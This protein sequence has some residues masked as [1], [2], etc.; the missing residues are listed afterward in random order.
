[1]LGDGVAEQSLEQGSVFSI[2]DTPADGAA[3]EDIDN[4][5]E[6]EIG[7]FR[8][9]FEF[10]DVPRPD[11]I[12]VY[13]QQFGLGVERMAQLLAACAHFVVG[14]QN[15]IHGADRAMIAALVEQ[16]GVDFCWREIGKARRTEQIEYR[17]R[18]TMLATRAVD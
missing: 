13:G 17:L 6:V 7:P 14:P 12:R 9:P 3:T 4:D 15:A 16:G 11:F 5:V 8:W 10:R 1:M 2:S 18:A